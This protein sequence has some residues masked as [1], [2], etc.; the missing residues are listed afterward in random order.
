MK[1]IA[2]VAT[3]LCRLLGVERPV[4]ARSPALGEVV[5]AAPGR[6]E[7]MLIYAPDAVGTCI[8]AAHPDL[9]SRLEAVAPL[10]VGLEAMRPA[11][12]PVCFASMFTGAPPELHG[13]RSYEKPVLRVD[14]AFDALARAGRKV[15]IVATTGSSMD[16][17]FRNR[18]I[19][20]Y[21]ED[22][23]ARVTER[24]LALVAADATELIV[25]YHQ[26]FDDALHREH[27]DSAAARAALERH[28]ATFEAFAAAA[29]RHWSGR[30]R[31]LWFA[32]DHGAHCNPQT[33]RGDH[34]EADDDRPVTHYIR[35]AAAAAAAR[36][37]DAAAET[38]APAAGTLPADI[39]APALLDAIG[40]V[41]GMRVLEIGCGDGYFSR[42][43][44]MRGAWVTAIDASEKLVA[45]ALKTETEKPIGI[46]Y[47]TLDPQ[48]IVG[49]WGP[50]SFDL[51]VSCNT[52]ADL[53][54]P[55]A[56][57]RSAARTLGKEGRLV[58]TVPL[59]PA[60]VRTAEQWVKLIESSGFGVRRVNERWAGEA[61]DPNSPAARP[62]D[63]LVI[64][65]A[66]TLAPRRPA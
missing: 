25:A 48:A 53:P 59:P 64:D 11:K 36:P 41:I 24:A 44:A 16:L 51:V 47:H 22:S 62:A 38:A 63:Y 57:L 50:D 37:G 10:R 8:L 45:A 66:P 26:E 2:A 4:M 18:P 61:P 46:E 3:T 52:I 34:D 13:I 27:P 14:T 19:A 49:N 58:V 28:V 42:Q 54:R 56:A 17:I 33:G 55:E 23:D 6:V 1:S 7:R 43:L 5:D 20:Y 9:L 35:F 65:A 21:S 29:D 32:P 40:E 39:A 60:G 30:V 31:C 12:T 15:A